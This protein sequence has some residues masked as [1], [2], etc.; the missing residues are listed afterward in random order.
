MAEV[1]AGL[2]AGGCTCPDARRWAAYWSSEAV[3]ARLAAEL[4]AEQVRTLT[5]W[6]DA[7]Q[8]AR[9]P[10]RVGFHEP[11]WDRPTFAEL[12]ERRRS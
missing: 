12:Q 10:R 11:V 3:G 1:I 7:C 4:D 8:D 2:V 9:G 6:G 5:R